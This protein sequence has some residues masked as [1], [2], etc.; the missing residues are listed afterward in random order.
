MASLIIPQTQLNACLAFTMP[1]ELK[2]PGT[3]ANALFTL[4]SHCGEG[5]MLVA[6][7]WKKGT[8]PANFGGFSIEFKQPGSHKFIELQ[9]RLMLP[10][11]SPRDPKRFSTLRSPIQN[12]AGCTG[13]SVQL[14]HNATKNFSRWISTSPQP[15][16]IWVPTVF[17]EWPIRRMARTCW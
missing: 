1:S 16:C 11:A 12:S 15:A 13:W 3:V 14:S 2:F 7:N 9:N 17:Q 6:M 4:K 10:G 5:M 8:P